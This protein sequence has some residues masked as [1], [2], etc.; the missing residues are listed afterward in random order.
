M[1]QIRTEQP[2]FVISLTV[3]P[4]IINICQDKNPRLGNQPRY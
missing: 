1:E 4:M 3:F 2:E